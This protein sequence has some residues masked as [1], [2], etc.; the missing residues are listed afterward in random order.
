MAKPTAVLKSAPTN[1]PENT[2]FILVSKI[3]SNFVVQ[4]NM[5]AELLLCF[6]IINLN[7]NFKVEGDSANQILLPHVLQSSARY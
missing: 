4:C 7:L 5:R 6:F 1:H 2:V 3:L